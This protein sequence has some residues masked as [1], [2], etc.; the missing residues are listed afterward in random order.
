MISTWKERESL[1]K[2]I[3]VGGGQYKQRKGKHDMTG[4]IFRIATDRSG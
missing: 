1:E 4:I 3:A 2:Q